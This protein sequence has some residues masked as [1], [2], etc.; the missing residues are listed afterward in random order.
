AESDQ[1]EARLGASVSRAGDVN[2]DGFD[3]VVV[4]ANY[5]TNGE[6]HEGRAHLY[7]GSARGR[8]PAPARTAVSD[9][10]WAV[11][12]GSVAGAGDVNADGVD[13]VIVGAPYS[14]DGPPGY[15]HGLVGAGSAVVYFGSPNGLSVVPNRS[16][17]SN[18][19]NS[20]FGN[21]ASGAGDVNGD[22]YADI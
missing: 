7:L 17:E 8:Q 4:G 20:M 13:D 16:V 12:G 3:D 22:G 2:G 6:S 21:S 15:Q 19:A 18:Q 1:A 10:E 5:Y 11:F 9:Q 14:E